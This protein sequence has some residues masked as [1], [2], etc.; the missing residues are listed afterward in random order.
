MKKLI[1]LFVT[2]AILHN[3]H[4]Q[5]DTLVITGK[6]VNTNVLRPGTHRWLVYFQNG[7]DSGRTSYSF[8]DRTISFEQYEGK[9]VIAIRQRWQ[10][11]DTVTHTVY[12][13]SDRKT[14]QPYYQESWWKGR[15]TTTVDML[16]KTVNF[17]GKLLSDED[18]AR[19]AKRIWDAFKT[20]ADQYTLNWHL[21]L[22]TF[23]I[24]PYKEGRTFGINFYELASSPAALQYY[25]V[26]GSAKL[27][28]YDD[29][30][31][32]CWTL[33]HTSKNNKETFFISKKTK[34]VLKLEQEFNGRYRFK[35]KL[36]F[37]DEN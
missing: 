33:V 8:W 27:K 34:E 7:K 17:Q 16:K 25:T 35:V 31:I 9:D 23:P 22:E 5:K 12:S 19:T 21:D 4:A 30:Q 32:D 24:L 37:S 14:F 36:S 3:V 1:L 15:G 28:G 6:D 26:T 11:N 13:V 10:S 20:S 18:T 29:T 2:L